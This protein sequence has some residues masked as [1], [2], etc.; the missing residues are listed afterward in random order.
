[1]RQG[2]NEIMME[3][4]HLF[5]NQEITGDLDKGAFS[6]VVKLGGEGV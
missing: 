5:G 4:Y 1:M 3:N 2:L 6:G